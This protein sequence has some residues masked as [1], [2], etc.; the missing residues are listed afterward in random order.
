MLPNQEGMQARPRL[1]FNVLSYEGGLD[2][3]AVDCIVY[4]VLILFLMTTVL[5]TRNVTPIKCLVTY[6]I[7][8]PIKCL[9]TY[10]YTVRKKNRTM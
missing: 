3:V 7:V 5:L 2:I 10:F 1:M 4:T 6:C 8:T 9:V